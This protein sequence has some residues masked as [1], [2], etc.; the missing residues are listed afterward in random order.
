MNK[1]NTRRGFTQENQHSVICPPCGESALKG[2]K[3]VVNKATLLNNPPSALR[4]TSPTSGEVNSGFTLIELL[5]VVL[6]IG[7][8]AAV[9][10]PQYQKAVAKSRTTEA[11]A[12]LKT[13]QQAQETYYLANGTYTGTLANLDIDIPTEQIA[14]SFSAADS[15]HPQRYMYS[16]LAD[17]LCMAV[18]SDRKN[19]PSLQVVL[20]N[21][22]QFVYDYGNRPNTWLCHNSNITGIAE[23]ICKSMSSSSSVQQNGYTYYKIN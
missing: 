21:I 23:S 16:C 10:V 14:S 13:L 22:S 4:A 19:L 2:G 15:T 11:L 3:G 12:I 5:V 18:A 17:G 9:A 8:L 1:T 20:S 6:I 7:I